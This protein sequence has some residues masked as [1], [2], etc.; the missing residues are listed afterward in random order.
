MNLC[1][2]T[3]LL[4]Y[5]IHLISKKIIESRYGINLDGRQIWANSQL[6]RFICLTDGAE[7]NSG[8]IA[9]DDKGYSPVSIARHKGLWDTHSPAHEWST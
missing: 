5:I 9:G 1:V 2:L 8:F 4:Y 6:S 3:G 7:G